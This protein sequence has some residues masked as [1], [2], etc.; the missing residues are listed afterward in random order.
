MIA[1]AKTEDILNIARELCPASFSLMR[2]GDSLRAYARR[3]YLN[4]SPVKSTLARQGRRLLASAF[5]EHLQGTQTPIERIRDEVEFN[6]VVQTGPHHRLAFDDDYFSTLAFSLLGT[7]A[8]GRAVNVLFN[9]STVTLEERD[10]RGPAWLRTD[11]AST[12]VFDLPRRLLSKRSMVAFDEPVEISQDLIRWAATQLPPNLSIDV[13]HGRKSAREH[14]ARINSELFSQLE[15]GTG[16]AT[17]AVRE[18][19]FAKLLAASL[20][21]PSLIRRLIDDGRL[22]ALVAD[23]H[24][25]VDTMAGTFIPHSTDLFWAIADGRV[26]A[27]TLVDGHLR[28]DRYDIDIPLE[29]D[30]VSRLLRSGVLIPNLFVIFCLVSIIPVGRALGGS[31]QAVYHEIFTRIFVAALDTTVAD[32]R[33]LVREIKSRDLVGWG[34]NVIA[35]N[36]IS[37][38]ISTGGTVLSFADRLGDRRLDEVSRSLAAFTSDAR[39]RLLAS[40]A[41][42]AV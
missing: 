25:A 24:S 30:A 10:H 17:V 13:P 12:R 38:L 39:W 2:K 33:D 15:E 40:S 31:Y 23:L 36:A 32:E 5:E 8:A 22:G 20:D 35:H 29:P 26:R 3:L 4:D 9:C 7:A 34:H 11:G 28:S 27:L 37:D 6:L 41:T 14:L 16:I 21:R 42:E 18:N 1:E 19:F